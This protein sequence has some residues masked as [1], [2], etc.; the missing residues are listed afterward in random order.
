MLI[1]IGG[2]S[3]PS[4]DAY[5]VTISDLDASANRSGNGTLFRDRIAVKRTIN[6]SWTTL[7]SLELSQL[8]QAL[9]PVFFSVTYLDPQVNGMTA[10]TFYVSDRTQAVAIK[11]SDGS[12][13]WGNV[14]F[15][16][17]ER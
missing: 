11:Q 1:S 10:G 3:I 4:P 5:E 16:L 12:Y 14:S 15:S 8:L 13:K 7:S 17:V 6:L 2:V 9:S